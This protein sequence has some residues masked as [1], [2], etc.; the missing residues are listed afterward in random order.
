MQSEPDLMCGA[1]EC[2]NRWSVE[3]D[4]HWHLCQHHA[5]EPAH[6]WP[7]ITQQLLDD[8]VSRSTYQKPYVE[9]VSEAQKRQTLKDLRAVLLDRPLVD[10]KAW[11]KRLQK[12][13][14]GGRRLS[15][16]QIS[17]YRTALKLSAYPSGQD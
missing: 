11:A 1:H 10:H 15:E 2:P 13:H 4:G 7:E 5:W 14:E 16:Y 17:C 9:P 8:V 6:R 12:A 3:A